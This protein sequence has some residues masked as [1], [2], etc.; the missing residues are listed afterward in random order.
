MFAKKNYEMTGKRAS[1]VL[2]N[3]RDLP[4]TE[5]PRAITI[6]THSEFRG[7]RVLHRFYPEHYAKV[8]LAR[9]VWAR[10]AS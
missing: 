6:E 5:P 3:L 9:H 7:N 10:Y 2:R 1:A 8:T 4:E